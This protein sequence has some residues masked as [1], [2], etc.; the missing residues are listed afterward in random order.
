MTLHL[1]LRVAAAAATLLAL[2]CGPVSTGGGPGCQPSL[3]AVRLADDIQ[4]ASGV[5]A[6]LRHSGIF[7]THNDAGSVLFAVD[8]AGAVVARFPIRPSLRDWE[9][10]AV[11][12]CPQG[13]SCLYLS[14]LGDNYEERTFGEILRVSEPDPAEPDTLRAEVFP[15]RLPEGARDIEALLV[16][17]GERILAI[18]K[19]R[20]H[21]VTVYRYP[22]ALRADTVTL[23]EVQRLSDGPRILPRQV[24]GGAVSP[25]GGLVALRTY[26]SLQFYRIVA[27]TLVPV[28]GGLVNLRPLLESQGE[29]VGI[30]LDG[31]VVLASEG[32][33]AGAPGSLSFMRCQI[34]GI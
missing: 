34:D 16:L 30:G 25:R 29:G 26:E 22:G 27:D 10:V 13:G 14:D 7:W 9:D 8:G 31:S 12:G 15:V 6:S 18:T 17:P 19:G 2:A 4:E 23:E 32:G 5:A 33:P 24:T 21:A 11:A 28:E 3:T 20:N 1:L